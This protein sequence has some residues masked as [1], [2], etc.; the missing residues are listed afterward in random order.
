MLKYILREHK[1]LILIISIL[2]VC[3]IAIALGI[4]AQVTNAKITQSKE[5]KQEKNYTELKNNFKSIFTNSINRA[6]SSKTNLSDEELLY[7]AYDI[8]EKDNGRYD[9]N[10]KIPLFKLETKTT[11]RI[12]K[13]ITNIF[14]QKIVDIVLK[15]Q[16]NTIYSIDYS[17]FINDNI[18]SLVIRATLKEGTKAQRVMIQTYNYD[19]ENDKLLKIG[20]ILEYKNFEKS[21]VQNRINS[22]IK[23]ISDQTSSIETEGYNVYKRD[24]ND[25]M[26]LLSNAETFFLDNNSNLYIVYAYGNTN[27]TSEMD[28]VI[29]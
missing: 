7:T 4:Y 22:E 27:N 19:L 14:A 8:S 16:T 20:D 26:Y 25:D 2:I 5:D 6:S 9:F 3:S 10:I 15:N 23:A 1:K 21:A 24:A 17:A 12:N 29:F 13:E 28:L 11:K 18:L